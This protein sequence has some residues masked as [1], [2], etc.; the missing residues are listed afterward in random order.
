MRR[1]FLVLALLLLAL[2]PRAAD[3]QRPAPLESFIREVAYLWSGGEA[4]AIAG[5]MPGHTTLVVDPA[6]GPEAVDARHAAAALRSLFSDRESV[7]VRP[8]RVTMAGG[9]PPRGF[10]ELAWSFRPRGAS[11]AQT[12]SVYV[13]VVWTEDGWR[14]SELRLLP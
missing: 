11:S 5:L 1:T 12:R 14:I 7:A 2:S 8:V 6:R 10:G 4:A 13:G 9:R 3:A